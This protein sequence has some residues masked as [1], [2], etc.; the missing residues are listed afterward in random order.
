M[1]TFPL[2]DLTAPSSVHTLEEARDALDRANRLIIDAA[3]K[4]AAQNQ[5]AMELAQTLG[6]LLAVAES[7]RLDLILPTARLIRKQYDVKHFSE[8]TH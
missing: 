5:A 6:R 1:T 4:A 8:R 7:G 2:P 3:I